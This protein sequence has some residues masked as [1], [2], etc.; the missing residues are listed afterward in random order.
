MHEHVCNEGH[1]SYSAADRTDTPGCSTC[2]PDPSV[3]IC[4]S[5]C[6]AITVELVGELRAERDDLR[7]ELTRAIG[8]TT[9]QERR[10]HELEARAEA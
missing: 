4:P 8:K 7:A 6:A 9:V 1:V 10:I 5:C 3:V 2:N